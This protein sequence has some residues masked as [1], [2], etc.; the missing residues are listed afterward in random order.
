MTEPSLDRDPFGPFGD[1]LGYFLIAG[2]AM[3]LHVYFPAI[4]LR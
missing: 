2:I 3:L 1:V 4:D